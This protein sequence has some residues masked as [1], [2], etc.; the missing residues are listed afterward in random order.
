MPF[1]KHDSRLLYYA[2]EG[3][4]N[5]IVFLHGYLGTSQTH[6]G[7]QLADS[8]LKSQFQ[9]IAPDFRGFGKSGNKKWG[10]SHTTDELLGDLRYLLKDHL[11]LKALPFLVGYSVGAALALEYAIRY[12]DSISGLGLVSPRPFVRKGGRSYPFMSKEKRS[13]SKIRA[14]AWS[15][16]KT[17]QKRISERSLRRKIKYRPEL[18][19]RFNMI[20][21]VPVLL[22]YGK[23]DT[24]TPVV[25]F[26]LLKRLLPQ[27]K[28]AEF[29]E[30]HGISHENAREFND[31]LIDFCRQLRFK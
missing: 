27:T 22:L 16:V 14:K 25:A 13:T 15:V 11:N 19:K 5:P 29:P 4:G 26:E 30:D 17:L 12:P 18:L 28:I 7:S 20:Q 3:G 10:E 31:V 6:W 8:R 21:H 9:L 24:V 1:Y 23:Q 2:L